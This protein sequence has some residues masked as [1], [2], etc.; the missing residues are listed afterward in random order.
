MQK[1]Q[2]YHEYQVVLAQ[3]ILLPFLE[4]E[5]IDLRGRCVLDVGCG[6]GGF[7]DALAAQFQIEG[8]G[9][10]Y[11]EEMLAQRQHA[12]GIALEAADF[13]SCK[14]HKHFD[15]I[16]L[17]DVLEHCEGAAAMLERASALLT[18]E[19]MIYVTYSPYYS[20]FGGHQHNGSGF[21][22]RVPYI[23]VLPEAIFLRMIQVRGNFYKTAV[24]LNEDLKRIRR[25]RL[26][27]GAVKASCLR[28]GL[29]VRHRRVFIIRPDYRY[30]FGLPTLRMPSLFPLT[31]VLDPFCTS[32]ELLLVKNA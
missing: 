1:F 12:P 4:Q 18:P 26:T 22:S 8:L 9:I 24:Y 15:F 13:F 5:G 28:I 2:D 17:R 30:M 31:S 6:P 25:A 21:F 19:G 14:F 10:D 23:Q 29:S 32:V 27:T 3:G 7:L 16:L 20:P 11:D